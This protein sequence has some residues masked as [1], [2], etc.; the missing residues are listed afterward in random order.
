MADSKITPDSGKVTIER[1]AQMVPLKNS[2]ILSNYVTQYH[3][4]YN[5]DIKIKGRREYNAAGDITYVDEQKKEQ[6][7]HL[8]DIRVDTS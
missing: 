4:I 6:V 8:D 7:I 2:Q 1:F 5:A 3:Q